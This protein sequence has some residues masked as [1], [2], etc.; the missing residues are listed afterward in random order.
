MSATELGKLRRLRRLFHREGS[1]IVLVPLDDSLISGP[2]MGL[3]FLGAKLEKILRASPDAI[4]GFPGLFRNHGDLLANIPAILNITASTSRSHHTRK[5][6]VGTV[7]QA[8][9]LGVEAIAVHVNISSRFEPEMLAILGSVAS[10]ADNSGLPL[11]AIMYPRT[12]GADKDDN[13]TEL[14][15]ENPKQYAG[16]VAH[17]ARVGVELGA[18]I[19]KTQYTGDPESFHSVVEACLPIPVIIAGGPALPMES[20]L[21]MAFGS[22]RA[23]G[24]GV[25]FGRNV[26]SRVHPVAYIDALKSI[27]HDNMTP[28]E[29][30]ELSKQDTALN[31]L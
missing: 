6:L 21:Q 4:M 5:T 20:M 19:I 8:L 25:S 28:T 26:F 7:M 1:R 12:E 2:Q 15:K 10:E 3:E 18:D 14:R 23:G 24:S 22:I 16:L 29:A 27:V 9:R 31:N 30:I 13:Y 17:A 11:M